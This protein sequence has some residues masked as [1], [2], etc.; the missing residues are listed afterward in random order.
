[1]TD[2]RQ[3][4]PIEPLGSLVADE[5]M[6][7]SARARLYRSVPANTRR[8]YARVWDGR[9]APDAPAPERAVDRGFTG[10]CEIHN[11]T[12]MPATAQTL[13][14]YVAYLADADKAPA[15][16]EQAIAAIRTRHRLA[17]HGKHYPDAELALAVLR[18]HRRDRA[19]A[20]R[21]GQRQAL[22]V[23]VESLRKMVDTI[24]PT[25][26]LGARDHALLLLGVVMFARRSEMAALDW[27][28]LT[29]AAEG[30]L[31]RIRMSKTDT[32]AQ[33]ESVPVLYGAF[34]GTDPIRVLARWRDT[35]A[36]RGIA[37]GPV[38]RSVTKG[39]TIGGRLS[40]KSINTIVA[41]RARLAGLGD[42]YSAHSLRAGAATIAHLNGAPVATI[43]R[44][45]RWTPGSR[46]VLGYIRS[47]DQWKGHP[48]RGVL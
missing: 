3:L 33:G 12:P 26:P 35:L 4:E 6:S 14:E 27:D 17:G 32:D 46:A 19:A 24:D 29:D 41:R 9:P 22:P 48:F 23:L 11:R 43:C 37:G 34:P 2:A 40:T 42:G 39:G 21:S 5:Q 20:G 47:V 38:L 16:I 44:L 25:T 36:A 30:M 31:I 1:M 13:A 15:T 10:W 18:D 7:A 28:D 45:G 8:A